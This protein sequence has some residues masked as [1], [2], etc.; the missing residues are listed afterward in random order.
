[1]I[2]EEDKARAAERL[3]DA[4]GAAADI[5]A[6]R[7]APILAPSLAPVPRVRRAA[8]WLIPLTAAASVVVIVLASVF[9]AGHVSATR[10]AAVSGGAG[11]PEFYMTLAPG[12]SRW[13]ELQVRRTADGAVTGSIRAPALT[14]GTISADASDR[15]FFVAG[16]PSCTAG[17]TITRFYRISVT[18]SGRISGY[19]TVGA[20]VTGVIDEFAVSPDGSQVAYRLMSTQ[21]LNRNSAAPSDVVH[22]MNLAT[23]AVR[24]WQNTVT[25]AGPG[26]V[27]SVKELSWTPDGRT[28]IVDYTWGPSVRQ[29]GVLG[30]DTASLGG[31]LQAEALCRPM[32]ACCGIRTRA[33]ARVSRRC[34]PRRLGHDVTAAEVNGARVSVVRIPLAGGPAVVLYSVLFNTTQVYVPI[35]GEDSSARYVTLW[36]SPH[37][38]GEPPNV[39]PGWISDG[40]LIPLLAPG[41]LNDLVAW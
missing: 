35:L 15:A 32:A 8:G 17:P 12:V 22:V 6:L 30:L 10:S 18:D 25:G 38:S 24:T 7:E 31:S 5:M 11:P 28:L 9:V 37:T 20:P 34:W 40:K 14:G 21:C 39:Q 33:A 29:V 1:M 19:A 41:P 23:G 4:F 3:R 36:V 16:R 26:R 27:R 13:G 2:T